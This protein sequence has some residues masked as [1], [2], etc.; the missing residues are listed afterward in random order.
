[1][2]LGSYLAF[3]YLIFLSYLILIIKISY[4]DCEAD[5][6]CHHWVLET[7]RA[8]YLVRAQWILT[9]SI[10]RAAVTPADWFWNQSHPVD[11]SSKGCQD[12]KVCLLQTHLE[13]LIAIG[14]YWEVR[15]LRSDYAVMWT[16]RT[17]WSQVWVPSLTVGSHPPMLILLP[18]SP[19]SPSM[20]GNWEKTPARY[21]HLCW[22]ELLWHWSN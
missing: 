20:R 14:G 21:C 18:S 8:Q 17:R 22:A 4:H 10:W 16:D 6:G 7:D 5:T 1:M 13:T 19:S 9:I 12:L 11:S 2:A 15:L 3:P